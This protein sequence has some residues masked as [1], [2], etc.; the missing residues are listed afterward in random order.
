MHFDSRGFRPPERI[1]DIALLDAPFRYNL[2]K[3]LS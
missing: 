1:F 3:S 2:T